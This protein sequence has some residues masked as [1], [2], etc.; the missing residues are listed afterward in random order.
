M[1][2][3]K[4]LAPWVGAW[5]MGAGLA[6]AQYPDRPVTMIVPFPP[7]GVAD[8]V[9]RPVAEA[10]GTALKQPVVIENKAGAGG[11]I[12]MA[13]VAK[14]KP[15]GYTL[16]LALS[17]LVVLPEADKVLGRAP[18]FQVTDLKPVA[19]FTADPTVLVVRA[20]SP[21]KTYQEFIAA[22]KAAPGK[23]NFGSS[24]NYGTM[25]IPMAML[26][27][28][29]DVKMTHV[30]YTGAGP[31]IV[32]L[33]GGQVDALATGPATIVQHVQAGKVRALAHWGD[34]RLAALPDVP[35]LKELGMPIDFAQ[36]AGLFVPA[37]TPEPVVMR[38]RE[39]ARAAGNDPK[40]R[41]VLLKAGSPVLYQDAPDFQKY[42][43]ADARKMTEVVKKIGKLE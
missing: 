14:S 40:V 24:G 5:A 17:S 31:A 26:M 43:D 30:P 21:W 34:G 10:L 36:W 35:S 27:L 22:A 41:E 7:G 32:G 39:A 16:L 4:R 11:G 18:A 8:T 20:E 19:R 38:L 29:A 12:G 13:Q 6:L 37:D 42:V 28:G 33:L 3:A 1:R 9:A 2:F 15:D 23:L 25:H